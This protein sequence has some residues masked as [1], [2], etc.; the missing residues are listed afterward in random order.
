[1]DQQRME[2]DGVALL[3]LQVHPGVLQ[4]V[5]THSVVHLVYA[6][7]ETREIVFVCVPPSRY[8]ESS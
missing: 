7:L 5:A 8:D 3:H 2:E 6:T 4:V 1:M